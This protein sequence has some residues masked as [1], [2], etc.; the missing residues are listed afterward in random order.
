MEKK[1]KNA[2]APMKNMVSAM[3]KIEPKADS[4]SLAFVIL[5]MESG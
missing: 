4:L 1:A 3:L 2:N 5:S